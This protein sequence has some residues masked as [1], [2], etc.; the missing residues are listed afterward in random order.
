MLFNNRSL[1][2]KM[3]KTPNTDDTSVESTPNPY[4]DPET[5][6]PLVK[7]LVLEGTKLGFAV[8]A[9]AKVLSTACEIAKIAAQAKL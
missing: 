8:Y 2:V 1:Q 9:G 7:D 6:I 5:M 4:L 3:V